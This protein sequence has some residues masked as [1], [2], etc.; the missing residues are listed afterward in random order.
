M[1]TALII[2][3]RNYSC[4]ISSH[5]SIRRKVHWLGN[6]SI[7]D[8]GLSE[9]Q[10]YTIIVVAS[11]KSIASLSL[12][13]RWDSCVSLFIVSKERRLILENVIGISGWMNLNQNFIQTS[14]Y[15]N[16]SEIIGSDNSSWLYTGTVTPTTLAKQSA[17]CS[18]RRSENR[19]NCNFNVVLN[20]FN[21]FRNPSS[22]FPYR[23]GCTAFLIFFLIVP[24]FRS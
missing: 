15:C 12:S 21:F 6:G 20:R 2:F 16:E 18:E 17:Y 5:C 3:H 4:T 1:R 23:F 19:Q 7:K 24:L 11:R 14:N 9:S 13:V 22:Q 8:N 10:T